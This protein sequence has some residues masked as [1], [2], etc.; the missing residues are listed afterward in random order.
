MSSMLS[1]G[2]R[3]LMAFQTAL[4]VTGQ[5]MTNFDRPFYSRRRV[6]FTSSIN[7]NGVITGDVKRI[8]SEVAS[9][10]LQRTTSDF[11][12]TDIAYDQLAHIEKMLS[13]DKS[14]VGAGI[15][16]TLKSIREL[17]NNVGS[18][19]SRSNYL[20]MLNFLTTRLNAS[21]SQIEQD[22]KNINQSLKT[23][24]NTVSQITGEI[25]ALNDQIANSQSKD[26][27]SLLDSREERVQELARYINFSSN[28]DENNQLNINLSNGSA[29]VLGKQ[30]GTLSTIPDPANSNHVLLQL[31]TTIG[32]SP[33][34]ITSTV[35]SGQMAGLYNL[36]AKL[37]DTQNALSRLALTFAN[38]INAQNK[39]GIDA[40]GSWGGNVFNDINSSSAINQRVIANTKNTGT[41]SMTVSITDTNQLTI[42]DYVLKF[43][44]AT[45][46]SLTRKSDNT[47]VTTG[48]ISAL[49]QQISADGFSISLNSGTIAAGDSFIISPTRDGAI[50]IKMSMTDPKLLALAWA[51]KTEPS[52]QNKGSGL[53][54]VDAIVDP[55][56]GAFSLPKQLNPPIRIEFLT[57]TSYQLVDAGTN[58][59]IEGPITYNPALGSHSVFPTSGGYNPGYTVSLSGAIKQGDIFNISYNDKM[60]S[61]NRNGMAM[62][63]LYKKNLLQGS[64]LTFTNAIDL[65]TST[66][67]LQTRSEKINLESNKVLYGQAYSEFQSISGVNQNE[68]AT[69]LQKYYEACQASAQIIQIAK[70]VFDT[71]IQLGRR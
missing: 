40:N 18:S 11:S 61:D 71:I 23:I 24:A 59:V 64:S 60:S 50:G 25:A 21:G 28:I 17:N 35:S 57:D 14:S 43:D 48:T 13:D 37:T 45:Q 49:P 26:I 67:S 31:N 42:S 15:K 4:K 38:A 70:S 56:N 52:Q 3:G 47:V 46:Y 51:V 44:T 58:A 22:Q 39:L 68:E 16:D 6:D 30:F 65:V 53:I 54:N 20:N 29:L 8:Y 62:E 9:K 10:N 27:L 32:V 7:S 33:L 36:Q 34:D 12:M 19:Q 55:G 5:N 63:D 69:D 1:I 2:L 66:V 41:E